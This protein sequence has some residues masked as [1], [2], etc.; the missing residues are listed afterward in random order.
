M[1]IYIPKTDKT[2]QMIFTDSIFI[3]VILNL[4]KLFKVR[5]NK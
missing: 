4:I 1:L 2:E 5:K 3:F